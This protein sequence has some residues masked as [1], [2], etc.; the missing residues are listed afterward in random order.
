MVPNGEKPLE[1]SSPKV[2][3]W[4]FPCKFLQIYITSVSGCLRFTFK[5]CQNFA[6]TSTTSQFHNFFEF[7]FWRVFAIQP[8]CALLGN[9]VVLF[10]NHL[11]LFGEKYFMTEQMLQ[12]KSLYIR[13]A[14]NNLYFLFFNLGQHR[15]IIWKDWKFV[16]Q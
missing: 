15:V 11:P 14:V 6:G 8:N 3:S 1:K 4:V 10:R 16:K 7:Y 12:S 2:I 9:E 5:I 13:P